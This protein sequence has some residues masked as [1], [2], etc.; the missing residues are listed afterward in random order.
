VKGILLLDTD[1]EYFGIDFSKED[2]TQALI[3][4]ILMRGEHTLLPEL[5][6][7][8]GKENFIKFIEMFAGVTIE[9]PTSS[10]LKKSIEDAAIYHV[11][12]KKNNKECCS[13]LA[14][15]YKT[16]SDDILFR[17]NC[18]KKFKERINGTRK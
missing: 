11:M 7:A 15:K 6:D 13:S 18:L 8:V 1:K 10:E 9:F 12:S 5:Y 2:S 14:Q 4:S 17:F 3:L 16:S